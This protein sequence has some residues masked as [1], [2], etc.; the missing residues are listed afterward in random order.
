MAQPRHP[1]PRCCGPTGSRDGQKII[2]T[3]KRIPAARSVPGFARPDPARTGDLPDAGLRF[4]DSERWSKA[5][6]SLLRGA[7]GPADPVPPTGKDGQ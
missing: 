4:A 3:A 6:D 7:P 2:A 1:P 5:Y